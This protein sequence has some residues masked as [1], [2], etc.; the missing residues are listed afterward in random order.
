MERK[1]AQVLKDDYNNC[2]TDTYYIYSLEA[3][4]LFI[5]TVRAYYNK[6]KE[7]DKRRNLQA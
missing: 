7:H 2:Y 5:E 6:T 1:Y 3:L 4:E